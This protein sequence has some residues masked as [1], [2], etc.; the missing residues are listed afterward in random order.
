MQGAWPRLVHL[1]LTHDMLDEGVYTLLYVMC[2]QQFC[3]IFGVSD[4]NPPYKRSYAQKKDTAMSRS[5]ANTWPE[6][7]TVIVSFNT[8]PTVT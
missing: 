1:G 7:R 2:W 4:V 8:T 5:T 6:L 3:A